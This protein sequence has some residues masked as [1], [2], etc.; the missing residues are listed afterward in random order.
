MDMTFVVESLKRR[1][2]V[3][4]LVAVLAGA[5]GFV[6]MVISKD[7]TVAPTYTAEATVYVNT[8][9]LSDMERATT[10]QTEEFVS[11]DARRFVLNDSVAGEVRRTFGEDVVISAPLWQNDLTKLE[12]KTHFVFVDAKAADVE[13][14][15]AAANMAA[16]LT[17]LRIEA[18]VEGVT[19]NVS[20]QAA[21]RTSTSGVANYG[22]DALSLSPIEQAA[23]SV[24]VKKLVVFVG[25]GLIAGIVAVIVFEY[26]RRRVRTAHDVER[27]L[28]VRVIGTLEGEQGSNPE[29]CKR[30]AGIVDAL[31]N[32]TSSKSVCLCGW[33]A[34]ETPDNIVADTNA[35]MRH[36]SISGWAS[37]SSES[38]DTSSLADSDSVVI[39]V[40]QNEQ[41]AHE[42][43]E[44]VR[45]VSALEMKVLG[46]LYVW[47]TAR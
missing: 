39:V 43:D 4:I 13:T 27:L 28:G 33:G 35:F 21:I 8:H 40:V 46:A 34:E 22:S 17:A 20:D 19:A 10:T 44:M 47:K 9:E 24:S 12:Q 38:S 32:R 5:L 31:A 26:C 6:S 29:N 15:I 14:A 23:S 3:V 42:L 16:E 25:V 1:W 41:T 18:E 7:E 37:L 45:Y 2:L 36:A 30:F 11:G